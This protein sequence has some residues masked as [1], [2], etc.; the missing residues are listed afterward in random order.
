M[1]KIKKYKKSYTQV[2]NTIASDPTISLKAKGLFLFMESKPDGWNFTIKSMAKQLK[3]GVDSISS[4][5][6]E[7]KKFG[8]VIYW[9][10][11]DGTGIYEMIDDPNTENPNHGNPNLGKSSRISNKDYLVKKINKEEEE[12]EGEITQ[13]QFIEILRKEYIGKPLK[14]DDFEYYFASDGYLKTYDSNQKVSSGRALNLYK[15]MYVHRIALM[16]YL[17]AKYQIKERS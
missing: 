12:E 15:R 5:L 8:Y 13:I 2:A 7:L 17:E 16:E 1:S 4:A 9:K 11:K 3:D 14:I 10:Q 6:I